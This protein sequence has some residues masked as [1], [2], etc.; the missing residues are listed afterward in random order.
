[1]KDGSKT[2][3]ELLRELKEARQ[4][5]A[6]LEASESKYRQ[7]TEHALIESE[8]FLASVFTSVQ[9]GISV[10]D[11]DMTILRVNPAMEQ[12]YPHA[13][14]LVGKNCYQA[15]HGRS[16]PCA[17]CPSLRTIRTGK[18]D[19]EIIP[20]RG[21]SGEITG[22]LDLYSFPLRDS[23]SGEMR[24]VIEYVRDITE[25]KRAEEALKD[26]EEKYRTLVETANDAII[27][28]D[29]EMG[30]IF[31]ANKKTEELLGIPVDKI[32]G[33]HQSQIHP[34]E[35][36]ERYRKIFLN[37]IKQG[38]SISKDLFVCHQD[39]HRIPVEISASVTKFRGR[40][41]IIGIFRDTSERK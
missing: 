5:L 2:K 20:R 25:R 31:D 30:I 26:S 12:W 40:N 7:T 33:L 37:H 4:R 35:E 19:F 18:A 24:G 14:P 3:E 32:I 6:E 17:V 27:V 9:D 8:R 38:K 36:A 10:L 29:A 16:K 28:A 41:I 22:W 1:M 13:L 39:G 21:S 11:E 23:E 15:Y 34:E